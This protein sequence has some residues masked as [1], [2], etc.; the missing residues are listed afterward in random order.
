MSL[1]ADL[2]VTAIDEY[3]DLVAAAL[4][5]QVRMMG[6]EQRLVVPAHITVTR[7][8]IRAGMEIV[9]S[10][11]TLLQNLKLRIREACRIF[12]LNYC[13][14]GE[15]VCNWNG[16][17]LHTGTGMGNVCV[18]D[19]TNVC[20]ERRAGTRHRALEVRLCPDELLRYAEDPGDRRGMNKLLQ[21]H[22][23][24]IERYPD[25]P[26]I[27]RCVSDLMLHESYKGS[28]KRLFL[29]SKAMELI[30]LWGNAEAQRTTSRPLLLRADDIDK[31][32][33]A[34]TLIAN[35]L[36]APLSIRE[37]A[38]RV[39]INEFKLKKGFQEL[40]GI[41]VF[42]LVRKERMEK[43][44]QLLD[45]GRMNVG[46]AASAL[47]YS[48]MSNFAAAFRKQYGRNPGDYLRQLYERERNQRSSG[49]SG[50]LPG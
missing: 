34:R 23:G 22:K 24:K 13:A 17:E 49:L 16:Q 2:V 32:R 42:E 45:T 36:E 47:G 11:L 14:S 15:V 12:E 44:L 31:L 35:H 10:D 3:F 1:S 18:L 28:M 37:L 30:A 40:F 5:G 25:S 41:T 21:R 27:R 26:D 33:Q 9:I 50:H 39:G 8:R 20:L 43:A 7:M 46:E 38:H 48:N 29:E 19:H 4:N 6:R